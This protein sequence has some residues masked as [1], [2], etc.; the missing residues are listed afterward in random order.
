MKKENPYFEET[1]QNYIKIEKLYK[2]G[3]IKHTSTKYKFL[4]PAVKRQSEHY[5]Y[6]AE[7]P[8]RKY[9]NFSRGALVFV[10]FGINIGGELSNNHWAIVLDKEDSP[11][12]KTL[13]V[14]PLTSK[15][16]KDTVLIDEII[17][18]YPALI[19]DDYVEELHKEVFAY[20]EHLYLNNALINDKLAI[21]HQKYQQQ[22]SNQLIPPKIIDNDNLE[23]TLS[24]VSDAIELVEYYKKYI[25]CSYAKCNNLQTISKDRILK[26]NRLDPVGQ[27]KVSDN[28]LDNI[29]KKLKELYL[30]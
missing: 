22:Y 20:L 26:K 12:K 21:L 3:K 11:Y 4:A 1:K 27:M 16:R 17:A 30:F 9:W 28:T 8:K 6:E 24:K 5:L 14:V 23:L 2:L 10:E 18:E 7:T 29:N 19:L 25:K 15:K 13:T